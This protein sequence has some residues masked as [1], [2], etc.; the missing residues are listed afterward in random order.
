MKQNQLQINF[1]AHLLLLSALIYFVIFLKLND[2]HMRRWDESMFAINTYEMLVNGKFFSPH[3]Y[4]HPDLYNTKPPLTC[5]LQILFVKF[6]GFNELALRLPSAIAAALSVILLFKFMSTVYNYTWAWLSVLILLTS[7]GFVGFHTARTADSDSLLTFFLL[8]ANLQFIHYLLNSKR[9]HIFF[10]MLSITFAF[11]AKLYAAFLFCPA[12]LIILI[13]QKKLKHFVLNKSFLYGAIVFLF[14]MISLMWLRELDAP[15]YLKVV[16]FRDAGRLFTSVENHGEPFFFYFNNLFT[17][18]FSTWF[19]LLLMG[20]VLSVFSDHLPEKKFLICLMILGGTY[21][22]IISISTT[23][24]FWYDMPLYPYLSVIAAYPIYLLLTRLPFF[25]NLTYSVPLILIL[26]F[27][28]PYRIMFDKAEANALEIAEKI[29]EGNE[30]Y[31][32]E[33]C[34]D[35]RDLNGTTVFYSGY[36]R[37]LLFYKYKLAEKGQEIKLVT[38]PT[39]HVNDKVLVSDDSLKQWISDRYRYT[40]IDSFKHAWLLQLTERIEKGNL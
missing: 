13:H 5:W 4:F 18:R 35:N 16:F 34:N 10:F 29:Q 7:T 9:Q 11:A 17:Y 24:L 12:Y 23:K 19:I 1:Y 28:Y 6:I 36:D 14:S 3:C 33:R 2:F 31:L 20:A 27:I 40:T 25:L 37:S 22:L 15:G 30:F 21:L 39:F 38:D 32:F 26:M 8:A